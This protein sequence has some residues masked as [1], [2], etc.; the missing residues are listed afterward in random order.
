MAI[1][2]C[3]ICMAKVSAGQ[4]VAYSDTIE[5]PGC[6]AQLEVSPV[7]RVLATTLGL[8]AAALVW[9][10]TR[11][12]GGS[13]GWVLPV[14][15]AFFAYSVVAPLFLMA[16]ADLVTKSAAAPSETMAVAASGAIG[17]HHSGAHH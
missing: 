3:P 7:S 12:M 13:L 10:L 6:R 16:T 14:V 9:R 5:C 2:T 8:V 11:R 17:H 15:Y 1:R 4:V